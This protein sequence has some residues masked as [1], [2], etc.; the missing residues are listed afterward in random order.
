MAKKAA[1]KKST[2]K[3]DADLPAALQSKSGAITA[4]V[5]SHPTAKGKEVIE[6]LKEQ[7]IEVTANYI[8]MVKSKAGLGKKR[9]GKKGKPGRKT[10]KSTNGHVEPK[11]IAAAVLL[12]KAAGGANGAHAAIKLVESIAS[13][14]RK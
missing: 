5:E 4:Y 12:F 13:D 14:L 10:M 9:R 3:T 7:G 1:T 2:K 8:S 6:A 11:A